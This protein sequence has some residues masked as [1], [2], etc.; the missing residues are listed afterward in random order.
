MKRNRRGFRQFNQHIKKVSGIGNFGKRFKQDFGCVGRGWSGKDF[1]A[2]DRVKM[3]IEK[4]KIVQVIFGFCILFKKNRSLKYYLP[5]FCILNNLYLCVLEAVQ[6]FEALKWVEIL[7]ERP[8]FVNKAYTAIYYSVKI[9][10]FL[11]TSQPIL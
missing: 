4:A 5:T 6:I 1:T 3:L 8:E 2:K 10:A 9:L 7:F 11:T